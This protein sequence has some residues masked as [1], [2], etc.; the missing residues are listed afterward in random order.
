LGEVCPNCERP[1]YEDEQLASI[2]VEGLGNLWACRDCR[3]GFEERQALRPTYPEGRPVP[4]IGDGMLR[5]D[6]RICACCRRAVRWGERL[7]C[8]RLVAE[9]VELEA[10]A[11]PTGALVSCPAC[12]AT[13]RPVI[14]AR[15]QAAGIVPA[16]LAENDLSEEQL[17]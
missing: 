11:V 4:Q 13:W 16:H 15:L 3:A 6:I 12:V 2:H 9:D 7:T 10:S 1:T 8:M 14:L 17:L 5:R